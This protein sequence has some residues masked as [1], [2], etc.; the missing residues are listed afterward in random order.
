MIWKSII[1]HMKLVLKKIKYKFREETY[2]DKYER[3]GAYHWDFYF[4]RTKLYYCSIVNTILD[5]APENKKILDVGCGDGLI[6]FLLSKKNN[7]VWGIDNNTTAIKLAKEKT[8]S[9]LFFKKDIYKIK[10]ENE[11][12]C[13][14]L[15]DIIEHLKNPS[16]AIENS[17]I[18]LKKEG[19]LI[20]STPLSLNNGMIDKFHFKEYT[21]EQIIDLL[22]NY[23]K[24]IDRKILKWPN[25]NRKSFVGKFIKIAR[26]EK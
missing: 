1:L 16:K 17:F 19:I 3:K 23:F 2:F 24:L 9:K 10:Y 8:K 22:G 7:T 20:L 25:S 14:I 15:S 4:N 18:T 21:E 12:D 6:T 11:F 13:V 5:F 26:R